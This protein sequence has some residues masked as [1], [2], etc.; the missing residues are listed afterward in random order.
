MPNLDVESHCVKSFGLLKNGLPNSTCWM[1]IVY[2]NVDNFHGKLLQEFAL[3]LHLHEV[4]AVSTDGGME[5]SG[6]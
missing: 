3:L 6:W 1:R 5:K 4:A 2:A